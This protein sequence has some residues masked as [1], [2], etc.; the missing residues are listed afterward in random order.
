MEGEAKGPDAEAPRAEGAFVGR[1][2][3]MRLEKERIAVGWVERALR[4]LDA[5]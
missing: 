2:S 1:A 3:T 4:R 5:A